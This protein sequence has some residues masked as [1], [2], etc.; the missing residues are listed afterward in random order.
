[1]GLWYKLVYEIKEKL[2]A[3]GPK[4]DRNSFFFPKWFS[5]FS[6]LTEL[7]FSLS[8]ALFNGLFEY[9]PWKKVLQLYALMKKDLHLWSV[10]P[11]LSCSPPSS[12]LS[13]PHPIFALPVYQ[14]ELTCW[15]TLAWKLQKWLAA[16]L[17]QGW[18]ICPV[19]VYNMGGGR[20]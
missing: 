9:L 13:L 4:C 2:I 15:F 20:K 10:S 6:T 5:S 14:R 16:A 8:G 3:V 18:V 1:M 17:G 7:R 11:S 19:P 12:S